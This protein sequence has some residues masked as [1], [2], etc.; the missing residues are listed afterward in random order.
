MSHSAL[1]AG[2]RRLRG[3]LTSQ[4]RNEDSDEQLLHDFA[5]HRDDGAFAV[6]LRRHGPMVLHVCRRVLRHEQDAEDAFQATFLVLARNADSLRK[7]AALAGFLHGT[8]YRLAMNAKRTV[9]RRRK[10]EGSLGALTQPRSPAGPADEM[11]WREVRA[12][13]DEEIARL[14]EKY[15][16]VFVLCCLE[17][18]SQAEAARRLGCKVRT[19]SNRLAEARK[20]LS[21]RLARRGVESAAALAAV[22][23]VQAPV[24]ALPSVPLGSLARTTVAP[25]VAALAESLSPLGGFGKAK[26]A[27]VILLAA[28]LM[29]GAGVWFAASR[30]EKEPDEK[31]GVSPPAAAPSGG[32]TPRRLPEANSTEIQGRVLAPDGKPKAGAKLVLLDKD[33]EVK[34]LSVSAADGRFTVTVPKE[35]KYNSPFRSLIAQADGTGIDFLALNSLP[36]GNPV[37]LRLVKDNAVRGRIVTTEGKPVVG[38]RVA[39]QTINVHINNSLD[40]F[41]AAYIKILAGG[42]G[43]ATQKTI[44]DGGSLI[45]ATTD[46]EGRFVLHGIG[47]ERTATLRLSGGIADTSVWIVNR[48]GFDP[49]PYNQAFRDHFTL[50]NGRKDQRWMERSLLS[51][52]DF[53][54]VVESEKIIRGIVTDADTGNGQAGLEIVLRGYYDEMHPA[55][56]PKAKTDAKGRYEIHGA[57]KATRYL[58]DS[59]GDSATGYMP[60][61]MWAED[62]PGYQPVPADLKVKKGV[63]VTGKVI[64]RA[65]GKA[66]PGM[67]AVAVLAGNPFVKEYQYDKLFGLNV[68]PLVARSGEMDA[69]GSFRLITLPG[70]VLLMGGPN[71]QKLEPLEALRFGPPV[72]DPNYPKYF[73]VGTGATTEMRLTYFGLEGVRRD[74]E[75][76][77]CKVLD[78]KPGVALVKQDIV[79]ERADAMTLKIQDPEG[80]P[81]SAVWVTGISPRTRYPAVRLENDS[82]P[83]YSVTQDKP[84]LLIFCEPHRKFA[85][86]RMLKA[87]ENQPTIVKLGP[88]GS[89]KGRVLDASGKPL[90]GIEVD[91][92]YRDSEADEIER[93]IHEGK[94]IATDAA[95]T[96]TLDMLLPEMKFELSFRRGRRPF[97]QERNSA[98]MALQVKPGE[99]RDL[100]AIQ[101]KLVPETEVK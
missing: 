15:R 85:S 66:V 21:R 79:L 60:G 22:S 67:A 34:R 37:E 58:I 6:L 41:L 56:M 17:E 82:C 98:G 44:W 45:T 99:C 86:T 36:A 31:H 2:L 78:I 69:E 100:G 18:L 93:A 92:R 83:V 40:T 5:A 19:V 26:M 4:Q 51:G 46:A 48:A 25:A 65:T 73:Q 49:K 61:Q 7:R 14:P 20:R 39:A 70:P 90:A 88:A 54:R 10:Y 94:Q 64:D 1:A 24:S 27:T 11:L 42:K 74:V 13:L 12:L 76:N 43:H 77:F 72:P 62:K 55:F 30:T 87:G 97:Q 23:L 52:P 50:A 81:L 32:P 57:R 29:S 59:L 8:A 28:A 9:A 80:R 96:F 101:L 53:S 35:S 63:I 68:M 3:K 71:H 84:R 89:I 91:L 33:G 47:A 75:G 95:G 38:A 16:T